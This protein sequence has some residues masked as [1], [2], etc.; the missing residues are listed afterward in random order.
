MLETL[1]ELIYGM[2]FIVLI[3]ALLGIGYALVLFYRAFEVYNTEKMQKEAEKRKK[4]R[5]RGPGQAKAQQA[6]S[7][8]NRST[9]H[10]AD[11][12]EASEKTT[13]V[14]DDGQANEAPSEPAPPAG[15][16]IDLLASLPD[17][18]VGQ[19]NEDGETTLATPVQAPLENPIG[20]DPLTKGTGAS[21]KSNYGIDQNART[22]HDLK[23]PQ[24]AEGYG[25]DDQITTEVNS[26]VDANDKAEALTPNLDD[27]GTEGRSEENDDELLRRASRMEELG[28]HVGIVPEQLRQSP[29]R[30]SNEEKEDLLRTLGLLEQK[31]K[32]AHLLTDDDLVER[33]QTATDRDEEIDL[34]A[35]L[36]NLDKALDGKFEPEN[37]TISY[38]E[39]TAAAEVEES[40]GQADHDAKTERI[41]DDADT[42]NDAR[43]IEPSENDIDTEVLDAKDGKDE[44]PSGIDG[45]IAARIA[46]QNDAT[47]SVEARHTEID[48]TQDEGPTDT[49]VADDDD[50]EAEDLESESANTELGESISE[51]KTNTESP[52]EKPPKPANNDDQPFWVRPDI[53]DEDIDKK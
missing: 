37:S 25:V 46:E 49:I 39:Q 2:R 9:V 1:H 43:A 34:D 27:Q 41:A 23:S 10:L 16:Q 22:R 15:N 33:K 36:A 52:S 14:I 21:T 3:V 6:E 17:D 18:S 31:A 5:S 51:S 19:Q 50:I 48:D 4:R 7:R 47:D 29:D 45:S 30:V 11:P 42:E 40:Y 38:R 26:K 24:P 12:T 28:F 8:A 20:D 13:V 53:F 35:I 32:D 44:Q